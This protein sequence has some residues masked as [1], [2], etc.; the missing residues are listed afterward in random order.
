MAGLEFVQ[1]VLERWVG[2]VAGLPTPPSVTD[3]THGLGPLITFRDGVQAVARSMPNLG[4][5]EVR[6][7][8]AECIGS[9]DAGKKM[10]GWLYRAEVDT[11]AI[12]GTADAAV[13]VGSAERQATQLIGTALY[14][15]IDPV[16]RNV[17]TAVRDDLIGSLHGILQND[18]LTM[19]C[20][21]AKV[22]LTQG[23][24][25]HYFTNPALVAIISGGFLAAGVTGYLLS[26]SHDQPIA[27]TA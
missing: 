7:D 14:D 24:W 23:D 17:V 11:A 8:L 22:A 18:H 21:G 15:S 4:D 2:A 1:T 5:A 16:S 13:A 12:L 20:A 26:K 10:V 27:Q 9:G 6:R 25:R 19:V 3:T